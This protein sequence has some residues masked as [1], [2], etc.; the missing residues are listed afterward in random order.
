MM[1]RYNAENDQTNQ[2]AGLPTTGTLSDRIRERLKQYVLDEDPAVKEHL[3]WFQDQKLGLMVHFG[4]YS[5]LGMKESWPLIDLSSYGN[6]PKWTR[7][8]FPEEKDPKEL[9]YEY[10][11]LHK[12][13]NPVRFDPDEWAEFAEDTGFKYLL[14]TTKHHDGF[15]MWDTKTTP[16]SLTGPETPYRT[17]RNV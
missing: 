13:F 3:E 16:Y 8:Q 15:C 12:T 7:W 4:L 5:Q 17:N 9:K 11:Q 14:F 2:E 6:N 10:S 1:I